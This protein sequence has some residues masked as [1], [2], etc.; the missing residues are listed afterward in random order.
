MNKSTRFIL[1]GFAALGLASAMVVS[2]LPAGAEASV[3]FGDPSVGFRDQQTGA[4]LRI[5][6]D[7]TDAG[8]GGFYFSAPGVGLVVPAA[9][10]TLDK[11]SSND[12]SRDDGGESNEKHDA[13]FRYEGPAAQ[14][15]AAP[16]AGDIS[17]PAPSGPSTATTV[18]VI[19]HAD[20]AKRTASVEVWIGKKHFNLKAAPAPRTAGKVITSVITALKATD[21]GAIYDLGDPSLRHGLTKAQFITAMS[22]SKS[23]SVTAITATGATSYVTTSAGVDF[24]LVPIT[25][26]YTKDATP[27]E[28][29][30][31]LR[32]IYTGGQWRYMTMQPDSTPAN[33]DTTAPD[34]QAP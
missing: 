32:L 19:G 9:P 28:V 3:N 21:L 11:R 30:A 34:P 29:N 15:A 1:A 20:T 31:H 13:Q 6:L 7:S 4:Y 22:A 16:L 24:A 8:A 25:F 5:D 26:A 12:D 17:E 10:A 33:Y 2:T 18:R 14:Y 23:G 27:N